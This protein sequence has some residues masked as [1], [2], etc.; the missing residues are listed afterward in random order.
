MTVVMK[1]TSWS[2]LNA[3]NIRCGSM[4]H[5]LFSIHV[6]TRPIKCQLISRLCNKKKQI[7][8]HY[9]QP[10]RHLTCLSYFKRTNPSVMAPETSQQIQVLNGDN[11][12][13]IS[14]RILLSG[15]TLYINLKVFLELKPNNTK[16]LH[17]F[18]HHHPCSHL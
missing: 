1:T 15:L 7:I 8:A 13:H 17:H 11:S 12:G 16:S 9:S 18:L 5:S 10:A 2:S 6:T 3:L 4:A 14:K